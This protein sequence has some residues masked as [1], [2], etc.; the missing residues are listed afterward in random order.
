[1]NSYVE[2]EI[3]ENIDFS[4][5][6]LL[7]IVMKRI[8]E[9]F[10]TNKKNLGIS[11]QNYSKKNLGNLVRVFGD[12]T[13]LEKFISN[14]DIV[15]ISSYVKVSQILQVPDNVQYAIYSRYD[16]Q[17]LNAKINRQMKRHS[18]T[19]DDVLKK[20]S[21]IDKFNLPYFNYFSTSTKQ[22][23]KYFVNI[24]K[25]ANFTQGEFNSFGLSKENATVPIF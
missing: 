18:L 3:I 11:F 22:H 1:M 17:G 25:N 16:K 14:L 19:R 20:Y 24:Y 12:K 4:V 23:F 10:I 15:S 13:D 21:Y 5:N 6:N 9:T 7:S 8:H 2:I